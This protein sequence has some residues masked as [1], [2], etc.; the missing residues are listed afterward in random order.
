MLIGKHFKTTIPGSCRATLVAG[1]LSHLRPSWGLC[2]VCGALCHTHPIL[3]LQ[4][5]TR[6]PWVPT[7]GPLTL[8]PGTS[9]VTVGPT[10]L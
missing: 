2:R 1:D 8:V 4:H 10:S 5:L 3:G 7:K 6:G 9:R